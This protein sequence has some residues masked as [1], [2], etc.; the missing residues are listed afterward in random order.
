[1][2]RQSS[3]FSPYLACVRV[4][5][6]LSLEIILPI[7]STG[8]GSLSQCNHNQCLHYTSFYPF[9]GFR[10]PASPRSSDPGVIISRQRTTL[11]QILS[12][13]CNNDLVQPLS[14]LDYIWRNLG[15]TKTQRWMLVIL[16][17]ALESFVTEM[18]FLRVKKDGWKNR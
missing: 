8:M 15:V 4:T 12:Q 17:N 5:L 16:D 3:S 9:L 2:V 13:S 1:M 6:R 11:E 14:T 18:Y 10:E 7:F